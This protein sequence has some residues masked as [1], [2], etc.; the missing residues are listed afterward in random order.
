LK[1]ALRLIEK[2]SPGLA[3]LDLAMPQLNG[4]AADHIAPVR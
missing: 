1:E 3:V 4:L 2:T